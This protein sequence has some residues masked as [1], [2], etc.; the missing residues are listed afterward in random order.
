MARSVEIPLDFISPPEITFPSRA[1]RGSVATILPLFVSIN[2]SPCRELLGDHVGLS[3]KTQNTKRF[4][5]YQYLS[6]NL[7]SSFIPSWFF[8]RFWWWL[9]NNISD[10][11]KK[12]VCLLT[13]GCPPTATIRTSEKCV[14][15]SLWPPP[16]HIE[17]GFHHIQ[18]IWHHKETIL[19]NTLL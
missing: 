19:N 7:H 10:M 3:M 15:N 6:Y 18:Q 5:L 13:T 12:Y 2:Y 16:H 1:V 8:H 14:E 4:S 9:K 11:N 17:M